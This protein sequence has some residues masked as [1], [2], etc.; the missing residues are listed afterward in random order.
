M[1]PAD[2]T[3]TAEDDIHV[4]H[5]DH[6]DDNDNHND[7]HH[8]RHQQY[9]CECV[10]LLGGQRQQRARRIRCSFGAQGDCG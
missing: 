5:D 3:A 9:V 8:E 4:E 1:H 10:R 2:A 7:N 6:H